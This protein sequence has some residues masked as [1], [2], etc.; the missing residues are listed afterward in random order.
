MLCLG[1][2]D[3]LQTADPPPTTWRMNTGL[4]TPC[5]SEHSCGYLMYRLR[6]PFFYPE[7][8]QP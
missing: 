7:C 2:L 5:N 6:L 3:S 4:N 1:P 8:M